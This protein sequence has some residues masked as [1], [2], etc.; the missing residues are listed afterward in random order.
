MTKKAKI[1]TF[2]LVVLLILI[3]YLILT[4]GS[5]KKSDNSDLPTGQAGQSVQNKT[6]APEP[7]NKVA[8]LSDEDYK[9][10]VK[11][12]FTAYEKLFQSSSFTMEK[13]VE[14]KNQLLALKG[15]P[16]KFKELHLK[17]VLA[18]TRLENY[19]NQKD[20]REKNTS[21][22]ITNQLKA[23]YSWLNN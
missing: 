7:Q 2:F 9:A 18:L 13:V 12:I 11:E 21:Q 22:Q 10:K 1:L 17:F 6:T 16:A 15:L 3:L 23:D 14:L 8:A 20:Q 5:V 4:S 19:L